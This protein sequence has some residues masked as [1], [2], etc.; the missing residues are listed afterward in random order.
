MQNDGV[1]NFCFELFTYNLL[2][3]YVSSKVFALIIFGYKNAKKLETRH[4]RGE[5]CS[6][7]NLTHFQTRIVKYYNGAQTS[8]TGRLNSTAYLYQE[9]Q[10]YK[11]PQ[12][13]GS[14][15]HLKVA[16]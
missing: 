8:V 4:I 9:R 14:V 5:N 7:G 10:R 11:N 13:L 3:L 15:T 6:L 2:H 12:P 16:A 1:D